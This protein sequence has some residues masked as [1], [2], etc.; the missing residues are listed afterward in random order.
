MIYINIYFCIADDAESAPTKEDPSIEATQ[1]A[2][3]IDARDEFTQ[4]QE[5]PKETSVSTDRLMLTKSRVLIKKEIQIV[6][7]VL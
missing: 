3:A 2:D 1:T 6:S 4:E 7:H 5:T